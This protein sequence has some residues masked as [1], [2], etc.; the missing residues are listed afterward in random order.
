[1]SNQKRAAFM[2]AFFIVMQILTMLSRKVLWQSV[3][4][5]GG[6]TPEGVREKT[7]ELLKECAN[8]SNLQTHFRIWMRENTPDPKLFDKL[9]N[10]Y[11]YCMLPNILF[12]IFS[13]AGMNAPRAFHMLLSVGLVISPLVVVGVLVSGLYYKNYFDK[14]G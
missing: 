2:L 13:I 11:T 10:I 3:C 6:T 5:S 8:G 4:K 14:K 7:P 1:M 12:I 9:D